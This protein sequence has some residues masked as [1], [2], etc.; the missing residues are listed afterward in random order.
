MNLNID[1][2]Q[3]IENNMIKNY[4]ISQINFKK[5]EFNTGLIDIH[6][7]NIKTLIQL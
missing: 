4:N 1:K 2:I 3:A 5:S 6:T 7:S